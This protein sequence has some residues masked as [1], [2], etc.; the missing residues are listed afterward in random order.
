MNANLISGAPQVTPS[1]IARQ[2]FI[3]EVGPPLFIADWLRAVFIHYA[4][5]PDHL[6]PEV[7]FELDVRDGQAYVSLVAFTMRGMRLS[8][9]GR[10]TAWLTAPIAT[11]SFL[12]VRTYVRYV[13]EAGIYFLAE[14]LPNRLS[15]QI[16]PPLFGLPYRLGDLRY[17]HCH[18]AGELR[19]QV[20]ARTEPGSIVYKAILE[21]G[22][23]FTPCPVGS[24]DAFLMERY[25]AFTH[26][27]GYRRRFRVWHTPWLQAPIDLQLEDDDLLDSTGCWYRHATFID[28]HYTPGVRKVWMGRPVRASA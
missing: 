2:R 3:K 28:A 4:V 24:R 1:E 20:T 16:G 23:T 11:H 8:W 10:L 17:H 27:R 26:W 9:G 6:Q 13:A 14:W 7:P 15:V 5:A 25:S 12:N 18:E 19:G 21:P 22:A